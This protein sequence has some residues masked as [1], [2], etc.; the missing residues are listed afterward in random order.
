MEKEKH[1]QKAGV[2]R[3]IG[4][5]KLLKGILLLAVGF[6]ALKLLHED[7]AAKVESWLGHWHVDPS[8]QYFTALVRKIANID[9]KNA[10]LMIAATLFYA[11]I[12]LTEG[13]GLLLRKRWA[14]M[15]TVI[16]TASFIPLEV[17]H[18]VR[19]FS[20]M[21]I[22]VLVINAAIVVY[23]VCRWRDKHKR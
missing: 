9:E 14:E 4:A 16:V 12:F 7:V 10:V 18:L 8:N 15:L 6:G 17:Y 19:H 5:F 11:A 22:V 21:K 1:G 3:L 2:V 23:L 13:I 20:A